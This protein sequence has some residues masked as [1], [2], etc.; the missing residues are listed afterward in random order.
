MNFSGT[1]PRWSRL[2]EAEVSLQTLR[3][4]RLKQILSVLGTL[5]AWAGSA[6]AA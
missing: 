3:I 1:R 5:V 4:Y 6:T 2:E